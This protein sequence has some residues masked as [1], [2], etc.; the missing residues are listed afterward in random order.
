MKQALVE[1][2]K[3]AKHPYE[4]H[5]NIHDEVQFSCQAEHAEELGRTFCN[6]L[7]KA[8]QILNFNCP[9]DGEFSV[10]KTWKDTH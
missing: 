6:A 10:G 4:M 8:G 7:R 2:T 5:G 3:M 9:I 1:F